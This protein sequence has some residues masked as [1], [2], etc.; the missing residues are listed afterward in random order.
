MNIKRGRNT[1]DKLERIAGKLHMGFSR[2][3]GTEGGEEGEGD[4]P[5]LFD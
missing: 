2:F 5:K 3:P 4:V 1:A